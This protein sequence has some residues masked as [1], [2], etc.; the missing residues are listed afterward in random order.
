MKKILLSFTLFSLL[1]IQFVA[2]KTNEAVFGPLTTPKNLKV[3]VAIQGKSDAN[4]TGDG[5]GIVK[6]TATADDAITYKYMFSDGTEI[7]ATNGQCQKQFTQPG[8]QTYQ[9]AVVASGK[10]GITTTTNMNIEVRSDF[11]DDDAVQLLTGGSSKKWYW[12]ANE[13]G[14]LGVGPNNDNATQNYFGF[15]YQ[16][17]PF[18]KA[19]SPES[20]CLY[21]NVL[22]FSVDANK[23][24]KFELNNGGRTFFNAAFQ[25]VVGGSAGYD[26]CYNYNT[27]GIKTVT[28]SPSESFVKKNNV[29]NQTRGTVLNFTD[30]GFMGY[31]I[32]QTSYEILSLTENRMV[33]RAVMGNDPNIAWYHTFTTTKPEQ[34]AAANFT[35]LVWAD[36]F[37]TN[38]NVDATKWSFDLGAGGWGNEEAQNYTNRA[39]NAVVSNGTL[40]IIAKKENYSGQSYTSAR[41][42]SEGKFDF[43]YGKVE[44]RAKLPVGGGTWPAIW[45]LGSNFSTVSWPQCGEIDIMEH[46]GNDPGRIH[47]T[48]HFP[49]NSAGNGPT[50]SNV[51]SNVS[52][53]FHVY[54]VVWNASKINFYVDNQLN[55][56]YNNS[57]SLPFNA[58]FFLIL[59][60][61]MGGTFGGAIATD[62]NQSQMEVDYVRVY[63]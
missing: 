21:E 41:L 16:A 19:A 56:S 35:N 17:G 18:E 26:F 37:D 40:K 32:G 63:Q 6:F 20:S 59:N 14:H 25:G 34:N 9:V 47:S 49:G 12:A 57:A 22:T 43:K 46:K 27:T 53:E 60:V 24:L 62:F 44:V 13:Q 15:W 45:M 39:D 48:L 1:M 42:K 23:Q 55:Y 30:N 28:L 3:D 2:C 8:V 7:L 54:S 10:G 31:Y 5:T 33:V 52:S 58:N 61:A 36:E 4:P 50:G 51:Y 11:K 38:G 29:P